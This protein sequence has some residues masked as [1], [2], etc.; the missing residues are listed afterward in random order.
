MAS[1]ILK[2]IAA[3]FP[4]TFAQAF[5]QGAASA[6]RRAAEERSR[7][8]REAI[9]KEEER[10]RRVQQMFRQKMAE[11]EMEQQLL[12]ALYNTAVQSGD[13]QSAQQIAMLMARPIPERFDVVEQPTPEA[14]DAQKR[15]EALKQLVIEKPEKKT[16]LAEPKRLE[17]LRKLR[18][19]AEQKRRVPQLKTLPLDLIKIRKV[20]DPIEKELKLLRKD[21][22]KTQISAAR[23]RAKGAKTAKTFDRL[24]TIVTA[25]RDL[26]TRGDAEVTRLQKLKA[27]LAE[28]EKEI[29]NNMK[30]MGASEEEI[31]KAI[32]GIVGQRQFIDDKIS[33]LQQRIAESESTLLK[34]TK[35]MQ[36]L[37]G[38]EPTID[39][40]KDK[41][42]QRLYLQALEEGFAKEDA[43]A[44]AVKRL[45]EKYPD[46]KDVPRTKE[47]LRRAAEILAARKKTGGAER[48]FEATKT[49]ETEK[50]RTDIENRFIE[51]LRQGKKPREIIKTLITKDGYDARDVNAVFEQL[52]KRAK[53]KKKEAEKSKPPVLPPPR[54]RLEQRIQNRFLELLKETKGDSALARQRLVREE[55]FRARDVNAA[56]SRKK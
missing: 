12:G 40:K 22:L 13:L 30:I 16:L 11:V 45:A 18:Q 27:Q 37:E 36:E 31:N 9:R 51:L 44:I 53:A 17:A 28:K 24:R 32:A 47:L 39:E 5:S 56:L 25:T 20:V 19:T 26:I 41:D 50:I 15:L 35:R 46:I 4:A 38:I 55:G 42:F 54:N 23:Q 29:A 52:Q 48:S 7:L 34:A 33:S 1:P 10:K 2:G 21:L 6:E 8:E 43:E 49:D 3:T 14:L